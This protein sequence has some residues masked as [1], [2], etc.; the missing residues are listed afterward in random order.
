LPD[1][2]PV[3]VAGEDK[4]CGRAEQSIKDAESYQRAFKQLLRDLRAEQAT[5]AAV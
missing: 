1:I 5:E 3:F 2:A 4:Q